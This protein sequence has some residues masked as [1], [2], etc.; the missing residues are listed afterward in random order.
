VNQ[1]F[2]HD[3]EILDPEVADPRSGGV[4]VEDGKIAA[5]LD[6]GAPTPDSAERIDLSGFSLAPGMLDLHF[7]GELIFAAADEIPPALDRT[8]LELV[9][10]GTTG[11]L[12]TTVAWDDA[13][14]KDWITQGSSYMTRSRHEGAGLLG[15]HLEGPWINPG[16]AGAQPGNPIRPF[17]ATND[18]NLLDFGRSVVKM[19]TFA[20]ETS[21]GPELLNALRRRDMVASLGHSLARHEDLDACVTGEMTHV[22]HLFNAMG[23]LHHREPGLAGWALAQDGVTCDLICDGVHVHPAMVRTACRA[24]GEGLMLITDKIQPPRSSDSALDSESFGSGPTHDAGDAIRLAD[25]RLAGSN[26]SLDRA[27]RNV[28]EFGAMTRLEAIA[29]STLRPA[30]LL[31]IEA[32]RGTLRPGARAD[33]VILDSSDNVRETW[34]AGERVYARHP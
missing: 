6:A 22:T 25:G 4:L 32:E 1:K 33:F 3:L 17:S 34:I 28:Q 2:L 29:A 30:R 15:V 13:R 11:F 7:H 31:G 14:M 19:V 24:K 8:A 9:K 16:A 5:I 18:E 23:P 26:L 12:A 20:P 21:G 27:V 10:H